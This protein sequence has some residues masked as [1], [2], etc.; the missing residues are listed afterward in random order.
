[1]NAAGNRH[2]D[3]LPEQEIRLRRLQKD[4]KY[5]KRLSAKDQRWVQKMY[6][7][8]PEAYTKIKRSVDAEVAREMNPAL[9]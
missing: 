8:F 6:D 3:I 4:A 9:W 7:L 2:I 5:G 1:M